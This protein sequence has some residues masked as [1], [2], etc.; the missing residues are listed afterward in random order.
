MKYFSLTYRTSFNNVLVKGS[1]LTYP[2]LHVRHVMC[3]VMDRIEW[4]KIYY[5][6]KTIMFT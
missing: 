5:K 6:N 4:G 3:V 1:R 2:F